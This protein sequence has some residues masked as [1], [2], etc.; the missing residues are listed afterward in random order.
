MQVPEAPADLHGR[1]S[2]GWIGDGVDHEGDPGDVSRRSNLFAD[3]QSGWNRHSVRMTRRSAV[4]SAIHRL[5]VA[6]FRPI[7]ERHP[8]GL[9]A[10]S[11]KSQ[12]ITFVSA[13]RSITT[14][15]QS[16][17][18]LFRHGP[19]SIASRTSSSPP[20]A[21]RRSG[22]RGAGLHPWIQVSG[23][24]DL[25]DQIEWVVIPSTLL[26]GFFCEQGKLI[27][28]RQVYG[29]QS[30]PIKGRAV[31]A[32]GGADWRQPRSGCA[33]VGVEAAGIPHPSMR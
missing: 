4:H 15:P 22:P 25:H 10:G 3:A 16:Q 23:R 13:N 20:T 27:W 17:F 18:L 32:S 28:S 12:G 21:R 9:K 6:D 26:S 5:E 29:E 7:F 14:G 8:A 2:G 33:G 19:A 30:V 1:G 11:E 31:S 24:R